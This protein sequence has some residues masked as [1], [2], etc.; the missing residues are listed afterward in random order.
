MLS[1]SI[2]T[3]KVTGNQLIGNPL[4]DPIERECRVY[5]PPEWNPQNHYPLLVDLPPYTSSGQSRAEWK[6]FY[7]SVPEI[8]DDLITSEKIQPVVVAFPDTFTKLGGNQHI[9]SPA[10]GNYADYIMQDVVPEV[11]SHFSCGGKGKRGVYGY[12]SGG[13]ASLIYGMKYADF[14]DVIACH[15]GDLG[16]DLAYLYDMPKVLMTLQKFDYDSKAFI[17]YFWGRKQRPSFDDV[18]TLMLLAMA[19]SYDPESCDAKKLD[20]ALPLL[21]YETF[22]L[23]HK[24]WARWLQHDPIEIVDNFGNSLKHLK[25]MYI[26]CGCHD[27]F[28][29]QF[30]ARR[31]VNKLKKLDIPHL[32][33]EFDGTHL[34]IEHRIENSLPYILKNL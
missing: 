7:R 31:F 2:Q 32:Y 26:D 27:Q 25:S 15:S 14:W 21:D 19:A 28:R 1:G 33:E 8:I 9:N 10:I 22:E 3:I 13:Y 24:K 12:S 11:E 23:D 17:D 5:T 20:F 29:L 18:H 16:F 34:G 30:S 6:N 4:G